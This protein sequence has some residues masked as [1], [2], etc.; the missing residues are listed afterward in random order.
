MAGPLKG[1]KVIE[2]AGIGPGPFAAMLL[3]DMG[4]EVICIDRKQ[5]GILGGGGTIVDRGRR[6]IQIDLKSPLGVEAVLRLID[7]ADVLIEGMR[8]GVMERLGLG[9]DVCLQRNT[10]LV[11]GRMTG[12]GQT[13]SMSKVAG[14]DLNYIAMTGVL[15]AMG[16][17]QLPPT[18]PLHL[19]GDL[20]GGAMMLALGIVSALL[21]RS[22]SGLG[23]VVDA[24]ICDGTTLLASMYFD[25]LKKNQWSLNRQANMLD[26]GAHFYGCYVCA[27]GKYISVGAIE[28]QFYKLF[29]Q[30]CEIDDPIFKDQ[31]NRALWPELRRQL[32]LTFLT[33]SR[34]Q[35][36]EVFDGTDACVA[37][38][39]N[40]EEASRHSY[41]L[42]RG[43]FIQED[44]MSMPAPAPK[45]SRTPS[46]AGSINPVGWATQE[47]LQ[48]IG[49][50]PEQIAELHH[51]EVI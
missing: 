36:M 24:A 15:N 29:L 18:P 7:D 51:S 23:Q 5:A 3:A 35:W 12:W 13:G 2:I 46:V 37:P 27:D 49:Y 33:R 16:N 20:G 26:G 19:V 40:F 50:S 28:P 17:A 30:L 47:L 6:S 41:H 34:D 14:H 48:E 21:E 39:L 25:M 38:V 10:R 32:E 43:N 1:F 42:E 44:G 9:P 4:A 22:K 8:P 45:F 11:Y 31:W